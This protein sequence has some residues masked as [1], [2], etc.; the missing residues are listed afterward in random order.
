MQKVLILALIIGILLGL[1]S[2]FTQTWEFAEPIM[3]MATL[4]LSI[5]IY[6]QTQR[7]KRAVY[8]DNG[9]GSWIVALQITRPVA[10]AVNKHFGQLDVLID[11]SLIIHSNTLSLPEHYKQIAQAVYK[12]CV[13]GQGKNIHLVM[14]GPVSL[15]FMIGQLI[16]LHH[17]A[18]T[19]YQYDPASGGYVQMPSP[20]RDWLE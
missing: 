13:Q 12:A 7:A 11:S 18:I 2:I 14:S 8:A 9:E 3:G 10:E 20:T 5:S 17:F 19:V 4:A 6:L 15:N 1:A 16:G